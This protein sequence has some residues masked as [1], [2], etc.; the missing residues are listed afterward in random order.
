ML[1]FSGG[2]RVDLLQK[3][4]VPLVSRKSCIKSYKNIN[5][6][7]SGMICAGWEAGGMGPCVV[8]DKFWLS[9]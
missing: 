9:S 4:K 8:S 5:F 6:V 2:S 7:T 1:F 3:V